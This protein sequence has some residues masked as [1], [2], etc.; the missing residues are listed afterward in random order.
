MA[1]PETRQTLIQRLA[2]A[3]D[4]EDWRQ[5]LNDYWGPVC[6]FASS[7]G[8]IS[9]ADA[10]DVASL[11]FEVLLT[12]RLLARWVMNRSAKLRTLL[13]SVVRN[14][15]SNRA[16]VNQ[17]RERILRDLAEHGLPGRTFQ[18]VE[19]SAEQADIF[20]AAWVAD[21]L[22]QVVQ[23]LLDE[24]HAAGKGGYFR[25]LYGRICEE[26]MMPEIAEA[27]GIPLTSAENYYKAARKRIADRLEQLVRDQVARYSSPETQATEWEQEWNRL[28]EYLKTHGGLEPA[29]R[30]AAAERPALNA[31]QR[32]SALISATLVR[33]RPEAPPARNA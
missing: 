7:R 22:A 15:L 11:T 33:I 19:V 2:S 21:S 8:S 25:V 32:K 23:S 29:I 28:G 9:N 13:C 10:E 31:R 1:F 30:Q 3:G 27:L 14:V 26:M 12:N 16:R 4:P 18:E 6:R 24:Y 17:G 20:Y 5:F